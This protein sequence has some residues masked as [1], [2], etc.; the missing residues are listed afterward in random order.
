MPAARFLVLVLSAATIVAGLEG[1]THEEKVKNWKNQH[2]KETF[3]RNFNKETGESVKGKRADRL[4]KHVISLLEHKGAQFTDNGIKYYLPI[5]HHF[6]FLPD[7]V[8]EGIEY[9]STLLR[10]VYYGSLE[11]L[12]PDAI[13]V[14]HNFLD[15]LLETGAAKVLTWA[16]G[17][18]LAVAA[19]SWFVNRFTDGLL[20]QQRKLNK[21]TR[22]LAQEYAARKREL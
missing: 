7:V 18:Y 9:I 12:H 21:Q 6:T 15:Q 16:C 17:S 13:E 11:L 22:R 8:A 4:Y 2:T 19:L 20:P 14:H 3:V 10:K 1:E 5:T